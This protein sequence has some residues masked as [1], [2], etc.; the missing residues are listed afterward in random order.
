MSMTIFVSNHLENYETQMQENEDPQS[1]TEEPNTMFSIC[2]P[3]FEELIQDGCS[4]QILEYYIEYLEHKHGVTVD[5]E[6]G[7]FCTKKHTIIQTLVNNV[8][9]AALIDTGFEA[10]L[11]RTDFVRRAEIEIPHKPPSFAK[12]LGGHKTKIRAYIDVP[13]RM[14]KQEFTIHCGVVDIL[15]YDVLLGHGTLYDVKM[16]WKPW[17]GFVTI[18]GKKVRSYTARDIVYNSFESYVCLA[19][20]VTIP[21]LKEMIIKRRSV[22]P[23][24]LNLTRC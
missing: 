5:P 7:K 17:E 11:I 1:E 22:T 4:I 21:P 20:D 12:G 24:N 10:N 19:E 16:D 8:Q 9:G 6:I 18:N 2:R 3:S 23:W 14:G 15:P 13:V